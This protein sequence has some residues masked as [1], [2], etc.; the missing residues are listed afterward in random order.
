[1][2]QPLRRY[3]ALAAGLALAVPGLAAQSPLS[4]PLIPDGEQSIYRIIVGDATGTVDE[5]VRRVTIEGTDQY[6]ITSQSPTSTTQVRLLRPSMAPV[7]ARTTGN[8]TT[9]RAETITTVT[10]SSGPPSGITAFGLTDLRHVLRGV[11][12][13][14][15]A[16]KTIR[17]VDTNGGAE[18]SQDTF[19]LHVTVA[20]TEELKLGTRTVRAYKLELSASVG[21]VLALFARLFPKTYLWYSVSS[22]HFLAK[23]QGGGGPGAAQMTM[24]LVEYSGAW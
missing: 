24:E 23:Y 2:S 17:F 18:S 11:D 14:S 5:Q 12:F 8:A 3:A 7:Y 22:P 15:T 1:M 19:S 13:S 21:G 6:L 16:P 4:D 9:Y 10:Y 20:G